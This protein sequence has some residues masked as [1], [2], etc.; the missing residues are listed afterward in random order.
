[1]FEGKCKAHMARDTEWSESRNTLLA[2]PLNLR[3]D[4]YE[5]KVISSGLRTDPYAI[6]DRHWTETPEIVPDVQWS[7]MMLYMIATPSPYTREEI[8]VSMT[9]N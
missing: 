9:G 6:D 7:D 1:M 2:S 3:E 4:N 5:S 8:K